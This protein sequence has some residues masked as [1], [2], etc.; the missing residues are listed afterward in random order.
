MIPPVRTGMPERFWYA[1]IRSLYVLAYAREISRL[2]ISKKALPSR[3]L[4]SSREA[5]ELSP[6]SFRFRLLEVVELWVTLASFAEHLKGIQF[7]AVC[8]SPPTIDK[9]V[10]EHT[11]D[12]SCYMMMQSRS[13]SFL[14]CLP[15]LPVLGCYYIVSLFVPSFPVFRG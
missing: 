14:Y 13:I 1:T 9:K 8:S 12:H 15:D 2:H 10:S 5:T 4:Y 7:L 11:L 3:C 6:V